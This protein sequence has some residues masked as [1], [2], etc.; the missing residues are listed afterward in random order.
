MKR[1][2]TLLTIGLALSAGVPHAANAAISSHARQASMPPIVATWFSN[3]HA[4]VG[5]RE[6]VYV[7]VMQGKQNLAGARLSVTI[8]YAKHAL[9]LKGT[10]TDKHGM[11]RASFT[12]PRQARG[13]TL[14]ALTTVSYR[15][16]Q[17]LGSNQ[18]KVAK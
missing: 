2:L 10:T 15:G 11:A 1:L 8:T 12:V 14:R 6:S 5:L 9:K 17:Y 18:V 16:H 4:R 7:Q 13:A 3:L